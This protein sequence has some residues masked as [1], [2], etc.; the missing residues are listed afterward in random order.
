M[1]RRTRAPIVVPSVLAADAQRL[2]HQVLDVVD[3][4]AETIHV[5]VMDGHLLPDTT[6]EVDC[7]LDGRTAPMCVRQG[8]RMLVAGSAIF[9][10]RDAGRAFTDP[11]TTA[12]QRASRQLEAA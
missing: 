5:D 3:A 9:G 4:G 2:A 10:A 7:G 12:R 11:T 1:T 6:I 8:A